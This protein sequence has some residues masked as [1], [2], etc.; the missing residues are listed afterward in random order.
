MQRKENLQITNWLPSRHLSSGKYGIITNHEWL[1]KEENR[2]PEDTEILTEKRLL[3]GEL[4]PHEALFRV[5]ECDIPELVQEE[6][7]F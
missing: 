1:E 4:I 6:K 2:F 3:D 7:L 5:N